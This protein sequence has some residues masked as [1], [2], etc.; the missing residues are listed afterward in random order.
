L[1][2]VAR[3]AV[4]PSEMYMTFDPLFWIVQSCRIGVDKPPTLVLVLSKTFWNTPVAVIVLEAAAPL[5]E[6]GEGQV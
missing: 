1:A 6:P 4:V 3:A 2:V 5:A